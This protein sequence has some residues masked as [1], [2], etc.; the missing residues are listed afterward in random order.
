MGPLHILKHFKNAIEAYTQY[1]YALQDFLQY[2][3][4]NKFLDKLATQLIDDKQTFAFV[5]NAF[6]SA[7]SPAKVY[8]RSKIKSLFEKM[9]RRRLC[10]V[11]EV[12]EIRT[13]KLCSL[14]FRTLELPRKRRRI[15]TKFRFYLCRQCSD[16]PCVG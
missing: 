15:H 11:H 10:I 9:A 1:E 14:C 12:D 6:L 13:T 3:T 4:T 7:I 16:L 2:S 8:L 5:V